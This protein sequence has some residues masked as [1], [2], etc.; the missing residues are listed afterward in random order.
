M[1]TQ[2]KN[3]HAAALGS[4]GGTARARNMSK[5]ERARAMS[6]AGKARMDSLTAE[7]RKRIARKAAK[8]RWAKTG[9]GGSK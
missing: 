9:K 7:E 4:L 3:P 8:A 5:E 1:G 6:E 2:K